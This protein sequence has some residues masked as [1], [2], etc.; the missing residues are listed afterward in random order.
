MWIGIITAVPTAEKKKEFV[1]IPGFLPTAEGGSMSENNKRS[2]KKKFERGEVMITTSRFYGMT[3]IVQVIS[4]MC[5]PLFSE[6]SYGFRPN[7]S[8]EMAIRQLLIYL[9]DD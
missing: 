1:L 6:W 2:I 8:C 4:P 7:R 3:G 9:N 5:E